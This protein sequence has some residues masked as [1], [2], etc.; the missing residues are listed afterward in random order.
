MGLAIY[1]KELFMKVRTFSK[2]KMTEEVL[3]DYSR[4]GKIINSIQ[5][6]SK[7]I[8]YEDKFDF[9]NTKNQYPS[10]LVGW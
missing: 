4:N 9:M 5:Y 8:H 1:E 10:E 3:L 6:S 7:W 2:K